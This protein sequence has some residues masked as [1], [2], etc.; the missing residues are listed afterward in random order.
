VDSDCV[1]DNWIPTTNITDWKD[2]YDAEY[3]G[4]AQVQ[5]TSPSGDQTVS[6]YYSTDGW[7]QSWSNYQNFLGGTLYE[8]D[9]YGNNGSTTPIQTTGYSYATSTNACRSTT[10]TYPACE[11]V[12]MSAT[13][14]TFNQVQQGTPI[15]VTHTYTYD[16]YTSVSGLG[17]GYHNLT[18]DAV[19]LSTF[20]GTYL[21]Q[22]STYT[23]NDQSLNGWTYYTVN[24][25]THSEIDA[26]GHVYQCQDISYD[27]GAPSDLGL[28][29]A[30]WPTTVKRYS[31]C[32]NQSQTTITPTRAMTSLATP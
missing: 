26:G 20:S 30:G 2:Y 32:A 18:Q 29:V 14:T 31:S 21:T 28:P 3:Q 17:S 1:G 4:F 22:H 11:V 27:E 5:T 7:Y 9:V 6:K 25:L 19:T 23:T 24:T 15:W 13:T 8:E 10:P 16:D 12:L